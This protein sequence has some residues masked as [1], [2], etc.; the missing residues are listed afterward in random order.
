MK[1]IY[2][3]FF[4]ELSKNEMLKKYKDSGHP[5]YQCFAEVSED[6]LDPGST[7]LT[8]KEVKEIVEENS[9]M[10][11]KP[12]QFNFFLLIAIWNT[13]NIW[14][15]VYCVESIFHTLDSA[16]RY[17]ERKKQEKRTRKGKNIAG[18]SP[19]VNW[20][21]MER[22]CMELLQN[23]VLLPSYVIGFNYNNNYINFSI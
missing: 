12:F 2:Y 8:N 18:G 14:D 1:H 17:E 4:V 16:P 7:M 3:F 15:T 10:K 21:N 9:K 13:C 11:M 22:E 5:E 19:L 6:I 23:N 20:I